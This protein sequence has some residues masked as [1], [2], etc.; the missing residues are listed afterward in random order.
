MV[1]YPLLSWKEECS[2]APGVW[3]YIGLV[4][5]AYRW[6]VLDGVKDFFDGSLNE[7]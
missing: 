2:F 6:L 1:L 5:A 7:V 4:L 3:D